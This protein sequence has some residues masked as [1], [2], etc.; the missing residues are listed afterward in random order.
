MSWSLSLGLSQGQGLGLGQGLG[1][2][3]GEGGGALCVLGV[4][5]VLA[6]GGA[7]VEALRVR[8]GQAQVGGVRRCCCCCCRCRCWWW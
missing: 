1:E 4:P 3:E 6:H 2:G 8:G 5:Q 7:C